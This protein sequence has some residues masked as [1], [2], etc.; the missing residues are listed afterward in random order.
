MSLLI[1]KVV[2]GDYKLV[3][4][5]DMDNDV[6]ICGAGEACGAFPTL[7]DEQEI[8]ITADA[9]FSLDVSFD[10]SRF[11]LSGRGMRHRIRSALRGTVTKIR[12]KSPGNSAR[13]LRG[14]MG[15][16]LSIDC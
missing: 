6:I 4:G 13:V 3:V 5:S 8:L 16:R 2:L 11:S 15:A 12:S 10:Q 9:E 1:E 7:N 14:E